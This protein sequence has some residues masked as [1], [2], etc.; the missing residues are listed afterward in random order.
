[1][2]IIIV[3]RVFIF[4]QLLQ[5]QIEVGEVM[6]IYQNTLGLLA[7]GQD[8]PDCSEFEQEKTSNRSEIICLAVETIARFLIHRRRESLQVLLA[9]TGIVDFLIMLL[10]DAK[11]FRRNKNP[12]KSGNH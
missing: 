6:E 2:L 8:V 4:F 1:M 10:F 3:N 9:R 12:E 11:V 5:C 7:S